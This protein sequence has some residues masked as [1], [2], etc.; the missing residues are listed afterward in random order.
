MRVLALLTTAAGVLSAPAAHA[1][2][3]GPAEVHLS[4]VVALPV[5]NRAIELRGP[6][7][8][9]LDCVS[10]V[11]WR[12]TGGGC[13]ERLRI[14]LDDH[15]I[16]TDG[17][18]VISVADGAYAPVADLISSQAGS[19]V[20]TQFSLALEFTGAPAPLD[21]V[22]WGA[23]MPTCEPH[24]GAAALDPL[25]SASS[26]S[27]FLRCDKD[28]P[29]TSFQTCA[30][31]SLREDSACACPVPPP[32][33]PE[34]P[35]ALPWFS[36][37]QSRPVA[38]RFV[39]VQVPDGVEPGCFEVRGYR[40]ATV[41]ET[42]ECIQELSYRMLVS[43]VN[44]HGLVAATSPSSEWSGVEGLLLDSE[45]GRIRASDFALGLYFLNDDGSEVLVD[46]ARYGGALEVC[47][48][49]IGTS[50]DAVG[51]NPGL[52]RSLIRCVQ[53][54][55][56]LLAECDL[57]SPGEPAACDCPEPPPACPPGAPDDG[58]HLKEIQSRPTS[59]RF[60]E[61]GGDPGVALGCYEIRG[62]R[63]RDGDGGSDEPFCEADH[64]RVDL[65]GAGAMPDNGL[66]AI[67]SASSDWADPD[68]HYLSSAAGSILANDYGLALVYRDDEGGEEIVD[69][70]VYGGP[71]GVCADLLGAP[72][73]AGSNMPIDHSVIRCPVDEGADLLTS[74]DQPSPGTASACACP[75]P[76]PPCSPGPPEVAPIL[77]EVQSRPTSARFI[78]L[79]AP[80]GTELSCYEIR[81]YREREGEGGDATCEVDHVRFD[82]VG[83]G[84][85]PG[86]GYFAIT[87]GGSDW[88]DEVPFHRSGAGSILARDYGLAVY[89]VDDEGEE[90]LTD[91]VVYGGPLDLCEEAIGAADAV[92]PNP[93][94]DNSLIRCED[95]TLQA[96][97]TPS[98]GME[99]ECACREVRAPE[100]RRCSCAT[101]V[102]TYGA[103]PLVLMLAGLLGLRRRR[104]R[105]S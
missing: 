59:A 34:L 17:I 7:G 27:S 24:V 67:T 12:D 62:Y 38:A 49:Q 8:A 65:M 88:A 66:L 90:Y 77:S 5:A 42:T 55:T 6:P 33:C 75:E 64:V 54:G 94:I 45:A 71:L 37:I 40:Q 29:S 84:A 80:E 68:L 15:T 39:E 30:A 60:I 18:F 23:A 76:P 32:P 58:V 56:D 57:P 36:E 70:A 72:D 78:E 93:G 73:A 13:T 41:D 47:E 50:P 52:E 14:V 43:E 44:T 48:G 102:G 79:Q 26:G 86:S 11:G 10:V 95:G 53:E 92:G 1:L 74:C 16:P 96:C 46:H 98:P 25:P 28:D 103:V 61:L 2:C 100:S 89:Y 4:E 35:A 31:P 22:A 91:S 69:R 81:G 97:A 3:P 63:Q 85:M 19:M 83:A 21:G 104:T 20:G 101:G 9:S 105:R 99:S 87:S 51:A 82:L